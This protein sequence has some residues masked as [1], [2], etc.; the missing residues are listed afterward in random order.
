M[1]RCNS[2]NMRAKRKARVCKGD[3]PRKS[4]SLVERDLDTLRRGLARYPVWVG[5]E[6]R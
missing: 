1:T 6:E 3:K 2:K 5:R 4:K